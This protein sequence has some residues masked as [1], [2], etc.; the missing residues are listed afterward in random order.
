MPSLCLPA[1]QHLPLRGVCYDIG[2]RL[3]GGYLSRPTLSEETIR[4][5][6]QAVKELGCNAVRLYG[7]L[8]DRMEYAARVAREHDLAVWISPRSIDLLTTEAEAFLKP[9]AN[10][11]ETL[12]QKDERV[13]FCVAGEASLD[14]KFGA[15]DVWYLD[16]ARAVFSRRSMFSNLFG[17]GRWK[18]LRH[19][20]HSLSRFARSHFRGPVTYAAGHW[21]KVEWEQ[22]DAVCVNYYL[23]TDNR[24]R[25]PGYLRRL[26]KFNKPILLTEFG[27]CSYVGAEVAGPAAYDIV[28]YLNT[29]F[30]LRRPVTRDEH[31]QADW[32]L[33]TLK[34]LAQE[35]CAGAFLFELIN[36]FMVHD[37]ADPMADLDV[38]SFGILKPFPMDSATGRRAPPEKKA[39]FDLVTEIY[40]D[41]T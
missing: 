27:C 19:F 33:E 9:F 17:F 41:L 6:L 14:Y 40:R 11:A 3:T 5:D 24:H 26:K 16:R 15:T 22:F 13:V 2:M 21:E 39:A 30:R 29:P 31:L 7:S 8:L 1:K 23:T 20:L 18:Q 28:D 4:H 10:F 12:R 38:A 25:F 34:I 32:I 35:N 36:E 37:A